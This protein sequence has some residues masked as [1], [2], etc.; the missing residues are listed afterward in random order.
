MQCSR[1]IGRG[2]VCGKRFCQRCIDKR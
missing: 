2:R 1:D